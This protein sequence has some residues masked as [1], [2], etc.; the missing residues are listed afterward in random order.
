MRHFGL[1]IALTAALALLAIPAIAADNGFYLGA[2]VGQTQL[3]IDELGEDIQSADFSGDDMAYKV[4]AGFRFLTFLGVEGSYRDF[5]APEDEVAALDGTVTADLTGYDVEAVGYLPLG[6]ADIFAKAGMVSWDAELSLDAGGISESMTDDGED[7]FYGL[8]FQLRFK[9]F[10]A[11]AEI[12]YFDVE[13]V[14]GL[15]MYS[16]GGAF[17]F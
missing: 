17:T 1:S 11:R 7:P 8:G 16:I 3:E 6:I 9:S 4:F 14:D 13:G 5:G 10:A 15:Y 12:E 2:S